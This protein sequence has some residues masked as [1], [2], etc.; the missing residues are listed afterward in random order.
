MAGTVELATERV[1]GDVAP[2]AEFGLGQTGAPEVG[3][4]R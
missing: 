2:M 4:N 1:D 3:N